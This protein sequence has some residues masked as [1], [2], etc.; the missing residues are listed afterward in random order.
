LLI[1]TGHLAPLALA[2]GAP[3]GRPSP[4]EASQAACPDAGAP[5][6][7][8]GVIRSHVYPVARR[9]YQQGLTE[10]G[11][12]EGRI[13]VNVHVALSGSVESVQLASRVGV[14][15]QVASCIVEA[16]RAATFEAP[17][18]PGAMVTLRFNLKR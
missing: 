4:Q 1:A 8:E 15:D 12:T 18:G 13:V 7:A 10:E 6:N 17:C 3:N 11:S 16:A 5:P 9:C 2:C 14:S